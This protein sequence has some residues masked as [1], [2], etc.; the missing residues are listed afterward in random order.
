MDSKKIG[1]I[2]DSTFPPDPRVENEADSLIQQGHQVFLFCLHDGSKNHSENF[3]G[4]QVKRYQSNPWEYKMSALAYTFP[5]YRWS[6]AK[7]IEDFILQN[8]IG[9]LHIHDIQVAESVFEVNKKF[10]L[11]VFLDLHEN[12]PEIMKFYNHLQKFPGKWLINPGRWKKHEESFC[13]KANKVVVV[14]QEAKQ[15]LV[16]RIGLDENKMIV[17]PNTVRQSFYKSTAINQE[18]IEKFQ[19]NFV[20]LYIGDTAIRRGLL[21]AIEALTELKQQIPSIKLVIVGSSKTDEVLKQKAKECKVEQFVAFEGWQNASLFPSYIQASD[22]CIS[23]LH[24]NIHHDTTYANKVFQYMSMGKPLLVSNA[25]AQKN[26]IEQVGCGLVHL[27][28]DVASFTRQANTFYDDVAL[29]KDMGKK[30]EIYIKQKF[31]WEMTSKDLTKA[32]NQIIKA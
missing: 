27:D 30:G 5:F 9:V 19:N 20:L 16:N 10:R 24:R 12:R 23:P 25:T 1:M 15:E 7:K 17:V 6:M 8:K 13:K 22:V 28:R 26:V 4:I 11:P 3:Q 18:I 14:T 21:L 31:H 2:L 29:R 32:Y